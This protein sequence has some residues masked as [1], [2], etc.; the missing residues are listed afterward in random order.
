MSSQ[1]QA[2]FY[3]TPK[4]RRQPVFGPVTQRHFGGVRR[5]KFLAPGFCIRC[6]KEVCAM[7]MI[8]VVLLCAAG[9][10][11]AA[12]AV[13]GLLLITRGGRGDAVSAAREDWV[14]RRSDSDQRGW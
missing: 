4:L 9:L 5:R 10:F 3:P 2:L 1:R 7:T 6:E 13:V 14:S 12:M 11:L 8:L